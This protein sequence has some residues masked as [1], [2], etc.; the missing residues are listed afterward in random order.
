[1]PMAKVEG[2]V[3]IGTTTTVHGA[4]AT[5]NQF[6]G[7]PF[8]KAPIGT[9]RFS[10]PKPT[11]WSSPLQAKTFKPSCI[12]VFSESFLTPKICSTP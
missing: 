7:I 1:M 10:V 12:Q 6:L 8:A 9:A 11:A 3:V 5:V 2:G 4:T